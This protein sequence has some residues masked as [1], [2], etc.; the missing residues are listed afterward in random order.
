LEGNPLQF[1]P[2]RLFLK[3]SIFSILAAVPAAFLDVLA[4]DPLTVIQYPVIGRPALVRPGQS[5][6]I[7]CQAG[8][9]ASNW[10]A[11]LA[12]PYARAAL[13]VA[14]GD[15]ANGIR[16]LTATVPA[17]APFELYDLQL[18]ASGGV[19]DV[20]RNCVRVI[21]EF[22][23]DFS[24][25]HV[26]DCHLPSV[27]WIG[28]YDDANTV[29][30]LRQVLKELDI[31]NPEFVLQTGDI[32]DNGQDESQLRIAQDILAESRLP[33][34]LTGG[35]HDLW[36]TGHDTWARFF[37]K[38][39]NY[40]FSY[41]SV[42]FLGLEMYDIPTQ[43]FT[44]DQMKWLV[45]SLDASIQA[46]ES[47]RIL[48]Y[49]YDE[50]RQITGDFA[51]RYGV[52]AV[53]YGHT[54]I[55][56]G[57]TIG[58]GTQKLNTSYTMNENGEYRLIRVR[59]GKIAE[60]PVLSFKRIRADLS[61]DNDGSSWKMVA[62]IVNGQDFGLED[63]LVKLHVRRDAAPF[64]AEG[65]RVL[66]FIDYG[67]NRRVYYMETDVPAGGSVRV[68]V[69]GIPL[70]AEPPGI[71]D[72]SPKSDTTLTAGGTL[73]LEIKASSQAGQTVTYV[74][75]I[76]GKPVSGSSGP[77]YSYKPPLDFHGDVL[78]RAS[79]A[80]SAGK[81][82]RV[83]KV[84]V[85]PAGTKPALTGFT[86]NFFTM[87]REITLQWTEPVEGR[88]VF[89]YGAVSGVYTGSIQEEGN[90]N[91]VRFV[92]S[93]RGMGLGLF[94]CRIRSAGLSS[95][96]F[97]LI[98]ESSQ[99]PVM[100]Y[101]V[102]DVKSQ[103]PVFDWNPVAGVPYYLV[104]LT[105]QEIHI[106]EDPVTG[107]F[108]IEGAN[109][110]WAVLTPGHSVQYGAPDPSRTFTSA[111]APL[112]PGSEYWWIV[113][114][115]YGNKPELASTVQ[116]GVSRFRVS[117][118]SSGLSSPQLTSPVEAAVLSGPSVFFRWG[119]VPGAAGYRFYPFK[120]ELEEGIEV[121]RP[122]WENVIFTT[123]T[124]LEY[125]TGERL[126][127]GN[128]LWKVSAV[129]N[130]GNEMPS[131]T[132]S[133]RYEA[134]SCILNIRTYDDRGT[135]QAADDLSLPRVNVRYDAL[136][137]VDM[138]LPLSTDRQGSRPGLIFSPGTYVF[139]VD[140]EGYA[141]FR[142][143]LSLG[144]DQTVNL[145]IRLTPDSSV[146]T[147]IVQDEGEAAVEAAGIIARHSLHPDHSRTA[148]SDRDGRFSL[149]LGPGPWQI[150]ASKTGYQDSPA[151][152]VSIQPEEIRV[153][154]SPL[155]LRQNLNR[156]S[157]TVL[158]SSGQPVFGARVDLTGSKAA[159]D[160]RTDANG[161]FQF[162][163]PDGTWFL[164]VTKPGF[165]SAA[166][167]SLSVSGGI[168]LEVIPSPELSPSGSLISGIVS[169]GLS[170]VGN[171]VVSAI[172][173][174][175]A[176]LQ[177]AADAYGQYV[178][179]V[180][181]GTYFL[182]A[183]KE[184]YNPC[185]AVEVQVNSNEAV[186]G[187]ALSVAAATG[188]MSGSVTL[189]G[190]TP[191]SGA[192]VYAGDLQA[193]TD[194]GGRYGIR[195]A[196][197]KYRV[198]AYKSGHLGRGA[199]EVT[200]A[201]NQH[202]RSMDFIL[203]PN[204]T[205]IRGRVYSSGGGLS[206]ARLRSGSGSEAV[207]DAG[208]YYGL[209]VLA[210]THEVTASMP[211]FAS[212][213]LEIMAGQAQVLEGN[214][215]SLTRDA[216]VVQGRIRDAA[217]GEMLMGACIENLG[218]GIRTFSKADGSFRMEAGASEAGFRISAGK[219]GYETRI[220]A[221]GALR[222]GATRTLDFSLRRFTTLVHGKVSEESGDRIGSVLVASAAGAD[223]FR[224]ESRP[225]G[226]F[227]LYLPAEGGAFAFM[228]SKQGYVFPAGSVLLTLPGGSS[229]RHDF[230][231]RSR[232]ARFSGHVFRLD[233]G[234]AVG[235]AALRVLKGEGI[236]GSDESDES[237][238]F[239]FLNSLGGAFLPEGIYSLRVAK[240]GYQDTLFQ[241]IRLAGDAPALFDPRLRAFEGFMN[242]TVSDE[243]GSALADATL[244]AVLKGSAFRLTAVSDDAGRFSMTSI[245]NGIYVL[246][247]S[248]SG[249]TFAKDTTV[250]CPASGLRLAL[251]RN[252]GHIYGNVLDVETGL[253]IRSVTLVARDGIGNESRTASAAD[254]GYNMSLLPVFRAYTVQASGG[255]YHPS[256]RSNVDPM[257]NDTTLFRL[258]RIYGSIA[259]RVLLK[260]DSSAV[261]GVRVKIYAGSAAW[262]DT[263]DA[264]G[265]YKIGRLPVNQ[266]YV[267][268]QKEGHL[269][270]PAS[271]TVSLYSGGD[272]E[273][274]DFLLEKV[275]LAELSISGPVTI[276]CG[277]S[278]SFSYSA[279]TQDG[280]QMQIDPEWSV[281]LPAA[282]DSVGPGGNVHPKSDFVG[283]F[284]LFLN[285]AHSGRRDSLL[286]QVLANL[287]DSDGDRPFRDYR[288][289]SFEMP[290]GCVSQS[291]LFGLK[292]PELPDFRRVTTGY[293]AAGKVH[294][295]QPAG[296][297]LAR[298]M[299]LSIPAQS[300][301]REAVHLGSWDTKRLAWEVSEGTVA[302]GDI[303]TESE[304]LTQWV[305]LSPSEPLGIRELE[306]KPDPF[307]PYL[308]PLKLRFRPTSDR[309]A[310]VFVS[311][312]IFSITGERVRDLVRGEAFLK[313]R[314]VEIVWDA[315][316][317]SGALALNGRYVVMIEARDGG[318]AVKKILPVVLIK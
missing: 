187:I 306:A 85:E 202:L 247:V 218:S 297:K 281:D 126:V 96:E 152:S 125:E 295:F 207:A 5:F 50:S 163:V 270:S 180:P 231:M 147:G 201:E 285:D 232:F 58:A 211:G 268:V 242:G 255:G 88:A 235:R 66:Q 95:D 139:S 252:Q 221:T 168:H 249:Y 169:D 8:S 283:N 275:S 13:S 136:T 118:P 226:V 53:L 32:V 304:V 179:P 215:F 290:A 87:D 34:F 43:T 141:P 82:G 73:Q 203:T 256:V 193:Q 276:E 173:V 206:G 119:A 153:L 312:R 24:F 46:G 105:D 223:T 83:W 99:A 12:M 225:D 67:D 10:T 239:G 178:L 62:D 144:E 65:G 293:E 307:S 299:A 26:P 155:I 49:H 72:Y 257:K 245:P 174:S 140:K 142:D 103:S 15:Y 156:I 190:F 199:E 160:A 20:S 185:P 47:G 158:N 278:A 311:V 229:T 42:R 251:A 63:A 111:P 1:S 244:E 236:A 175:G 121:V 145:D 123:G 38:V 309:S 75:E 237:G 134:P 222:A 68:S 228:V 2:V 79:A 208:G 264:A 74:W 234:R 317:D 112:V 76:N 227:S 230:S 212:K 316:T 214:S 30:E 220:A 204:A 195:L 310:E 77:V 267:S 71:A 130:S 273:G 151:V 282:F 60:H 56:G 132:R 148:A 296:F 55:N 135:P 253:G 161:R 31:L 69:T 102:G 197:G 209:N 131:G 61:P 248:K 23:K 198:M 51:D 150:L 177:A 89:E 27:S 143:T 250:T 262:W 36:Y 157:G 92:P 3:R 129:D 4:S 167:R 59:D 117:M 194:N 159:Q 45:R 292:Y 19:D 11:V 171:A 298:P 16:R 106:S 286:V 279:R 48:F 108:S 219:Q 14:A 109:P 35:N 146:I 154:S 40:G 64:T 303:R 284:R 238:A 52:D 189:D 104:I 122:V 116:S 191:V 127:K 224:T 265:S 205:V 164:V 7:E 137:G 233:D 91:R 172:P 166:G 277:R 261:P 128:Y 133:F 260:N 115:C 184:G 124:V 94:H 86:R 289:A 113:L 54:H 80:T 28:F 246:S 280:R 313:G 266:Y 6:V 302:A 81:A 176:V 300:G 318:G 44:S 217:T 258:R 196:P 272:R 33:L 22:K 188:L 107:E 149:S 114:N 216:A 18:Q 241:D 308:E 9:S 315:R 305:V 291:V 213:T 240:R 170:T 39:M 254:G 263:T 25:V 120:I 162:S 274:V 100:A 182:R 287:R 21:P 269:S 98:I 70:S 17:D 29:P 110:I 288:G 192:V 314:R 57:Q 37:G 271:Q 97:R 93:D 183:A 78:I 181:A 138:G 210:G 243:K 200:V 186:T 301:D 165:S 259:G 101:P 90:L 41:G 294:A 84:Y